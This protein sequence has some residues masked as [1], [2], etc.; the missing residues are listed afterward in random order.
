M[1]GQFTID[2]YEGHSLTAEL[3]EEFKLSSNED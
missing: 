1:S 2:A 3:E